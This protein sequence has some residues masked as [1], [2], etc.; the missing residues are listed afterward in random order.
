MVLFFYHRLDFVISEI[1]R[2]ISIDKLYYYFLYIGEFYEC[3][4]YC[5]M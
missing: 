4:K 2:G 1:I 3:S 5:E